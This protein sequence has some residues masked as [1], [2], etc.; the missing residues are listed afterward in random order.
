MKEHFKKHEITYLIIFSACCLILSTVFI[1]LGTEAKK[2]NRYTKEEAIG[3]MK[4]KADQLTRLI[5]IGSSDDS[6]KEDKTVTLTSKEM[7]TYG[8]DEKLYKKVVYTL[9][10]DDKKQIVSISI[11]GKGNLSGYQ[12]KNYVSNQAKK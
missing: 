2:K 1:Y 8:F 11:T 12:L 3:I 7:E 6:C 5:E 9:K 10:C 4:L